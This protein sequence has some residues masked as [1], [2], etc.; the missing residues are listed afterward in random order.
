MHLNGYVNTMSLNKVGII[1]PNLIWKMFQVVLKIFPWL[2]IRIWFVIFILRLC[3][4][5]DN[6][7]DYFSLFNLPSAPKIFLK[8]FQVP[9]RQSFANWRH[10]SFFSSDTSPFFN[11]MQVWGECASGTNISQTG[12]NP[13]PNQRRNSFYCHNENYHRRY[14]LFGP[15]LRKDLI[16]FSVYFIFIWWITWSE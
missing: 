14:L 9:I 4:F 11:G 3:I 7:W 16:N 5:H 6:C 15:S 12:V 2:L 1:C 8:C 13:A 10:H